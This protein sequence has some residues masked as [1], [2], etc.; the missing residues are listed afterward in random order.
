MTA[1]PT[2]LGLTLIA[3]YW[4]VMLG[5]VVNNVTHPQTAPLTYSQQ[6]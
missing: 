6:S 5:L 2:R 1:L 4:L 3:I